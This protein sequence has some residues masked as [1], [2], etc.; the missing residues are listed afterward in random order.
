M[1]QDQKQ[2]ASENYNTKLKVQSVPISIN[3]TCLFPDYNKKIQV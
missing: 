2:L 3:A 1:R